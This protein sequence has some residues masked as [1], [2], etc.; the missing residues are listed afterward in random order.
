M[1]LSKLS[2]QL[3]EQSNRISNLNDRNSLLEKGVA[4]IFSIW[5]TFFKT[6]GVMLSLGI[7]IF[8][9]NIVRNIY[10]LNGKA[11]FNIIVLGGIMFVV[12]LALLIFLTWMIVNALLVDK[13]TDC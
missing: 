12:V 11:P 2:S 1:G 6:I 9:T 7:A 4:S 3:R 10:Y 13:I 5:D 8:V